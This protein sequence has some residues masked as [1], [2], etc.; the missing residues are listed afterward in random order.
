MLSLSLAR[1]AGVP[2]LDNVGDG[3]ELLLGGD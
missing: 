1:K 3:I 2:G